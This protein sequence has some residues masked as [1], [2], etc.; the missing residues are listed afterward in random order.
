MA[1]LLI[2]EDNNSM[3]EAMEAM[4][5]R[6]NHTCATASC[7]TDGIELVRRQKFDLI[8]TD[9][10]M[11]DI[12]GMQVLQQ[13]KQQS[14]ETDVLMI[15]AYG[16]VE[17]AVEAMKAGAIDF[18]TKP[19]SH[20]EFKLKIETLLVRIAERQELARMHDENRYLR[21]ALEVQF[22]FGE[23]VGDSAPM[24]QVYKTISK[25]APTSSSVMIY[26]ES[27]TGKEL[28]ARAIHKTSP[29]SQY[30]FVRVHCGALAEGVLESEL[31]G[32]EKGAFTGAVSRKKGRFELAHLGT[33]FLDEIGDI[34]PGMQLKL[35][36]VVQE[37]ELERV[38]GEETI[39]VDVR[40]LA[41]THRNLQ[42]AVKDGTFRED[43][44]YRLH[45]L[46]IYLPPLRERHEDIPVLVQHFLK[47]VGAEVN[48]PDLQ[49]SDAA[50]HT[51]KQ[52]RW[53]GNIRELEN[54]IERAAVLC[55]TNVIQMTDL[56]FLHESRAHEVN[57]TYSDSLDLTETL[58]KIEKQLIETALERAK[59]VKSEA[60][61]LLNVKTSALYYK[62]E[63]YGL[64]EKSVQDNSGIDL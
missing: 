27:G 2:I 43:L 41:A 34:S 21:E 24:Q 4:V 56:P 6:M 15:T 18:I 1:H 45:I 55:E 9:Y 44:Y 30:P 31:F 13:I 40:I 58:E 51:L 35:L 23:I 33:I 26:G 7:G 25:V 5:K 47:K 63:K 11:D 54:V 14:P 17:L 20:D 8:I 38:G 36:R 37:R 10:K 12:D 42:Q 62:L 29:R 61:R 49:I 22:N 32:H 52:Y 3:R 28:I 48:K 59:G 39:Q 53:P 57:Q 64:I 19:F 60:A 50:I 16:T 46:P